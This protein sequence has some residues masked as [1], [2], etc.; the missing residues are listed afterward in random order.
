MK[1]STTLGARLA[2]GFGSLMLIAG[3]LGLANYYS[4]SRNAQSLQHVTGKAMPAVESLLTLSDQFNIIKAAARTLLSLEAHPAIRQR[5]LETV[6][7]ARE[8][9]ETAWKAYEALPRNSAEEALWKE[10][11]L[12]WQAWR[13]DNDEFFRQSQEFDKLAE[14]YQRTEHAKTISYLEALDQAVLTAK[15]AKVEFKGQIQEWKDILLRGHNAADFAKYVDNF[16]KQEKAVQEGLAQLQG[17]M[18]DL[19][20]DTSP[21][22]K[23]AG[24]HAELGAK[25]REALK[26]F[27]QTNAEAAKVVDALVKGLDRPLTDGFETVLASV[28][29]AQQKVRQL[30][31]A[32]D[33][34]SLVVCRATQLKLD[35]ALLKLVKLTQDE[36]AGTSRQA[37]ALGAF[38]RT[39]SLTTTVI[40]LLAGL[41]LTL[42]ITRSTTRPITQ[43]VHLLQ[44]AA[45]GD[46][47]TKIQVRSCEEINQLAD[48]ANQMIANL[49]DTAHIAERISAGDLTAKVKLLSDKDTLGFA[50]E[51]MVANLQS[52]V[53]I[54]ERIA[55][56]DLTA[57]VKLL[58]DKDTLGLALERMVGNLQSTV[59]V[60]ERISTGDLTAKVRLLS[61]KDALGFAL[62]RMVQNLSQVV[63]EVTAASNNVASGSQEMSA[64]AQQ[65]SQGAT[66]QSASAEECTSSMEEM[67]SSIQQNADNAQQTNQIAAKAAADA[68]T[69][70]EAVTR[71]IAAM[72]E[73][74]EKI[75]IIEEIARKTDLLALNAAVEAAR[76]GEHGKGFAVVASEVR[77]LAERSQ[78]AAAEISRL[79][80]EGVTRAEGA[81][82]M[83]A[84]LVPDIRKTADLVREISAASTEQNSG[85]AQINQALQQLDQVIQQNAAASEEMA[86]TSEELSSQAELLQS[87]VAFFKLETG[88]R[89]PA[90]A[91][92]AKP[93]VAKSTPRTSRTPLPALKTGDKPAGHGRGSAQAEPVKPA[94]LKLEL[95]PP[96]PAGTDSRD[97][98]FEHYTA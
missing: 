94:G 80:S 81:G 6:A 77:K 65:L 30:Q 68:Q 74:A 85:T 8:K 10:V 39:L 4:A 61:D 42:L 11:Q 20:L 63:S 92:P 71:T 58:S 82:Q 83:L 64:T 54:A 86:S 93:L 95:P 70:G 5:Q 35:D 34:Q 72:K 18:K 45:Q 47:S 67:S 16:G 1:K 78:T 84:K 57:Q 43:V 33:R 26:S 91:A 90:A 29:Q 17:L 22:S 62:E 2:L 96:S 12:T 36:A 52:T 89:A 40:G 25:Y 66:E 73:I 28:K 48:S 76:A 97:R 87:T 13:A 23:L 9:Y 53:A 19:G 44:T 41:A 27:S 37:T 55:A 51:K 7:K 56:G 31:T 38:F 49:Q 14:G 50:L 88:P 60:A 69:S 98:D 15:D 75:N 46:L 32:L 79:S 21:V 3:I 59:A 24:T